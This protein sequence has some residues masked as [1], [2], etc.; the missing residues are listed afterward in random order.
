MRHAYT[1]AGA[2]VL[3]AATG[4]F[5]SAQD[6]DRVIPGGGIHVQGWIGKVGR[7]VS[8]SRPFGERRPIRP[9]RQRPSRHD[10]A[11]QTFWN[12]ANTTSGDYTV[13]ATFR[14]PKFMALNSHP[15]SSASSSAEAQWAPIR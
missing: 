1:A 9:G 10:R 11:G 8:P 2:I 15:H 14:E 13:K 6:A 12:P 7:V 4:T 3:A 5:L